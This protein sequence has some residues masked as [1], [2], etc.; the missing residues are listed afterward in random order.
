MDEE[1]DGSLQEAHQSR[2]ARRR[3]SS[4][5]DAPL[6]R[7]SRFAVLTES[8][9]ESEPLIRAAIPSR[10]EDVVNSPS[11]FRC[12]GCAFGTVGHN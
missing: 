2:R 9:D 1:S 10:N 3:V 8:D 7:R 12:S 4:N 6:I 11:I 5:S